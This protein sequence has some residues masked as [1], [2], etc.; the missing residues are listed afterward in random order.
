MKIRLANNLMVILNHELKAL[1]IR[2]IWNLA[3]LCK[4]FDSPPQRPQENLAFDK[5][6]TREWTK[7]L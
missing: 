7:L 6:P 5:G 3:T 4:G 1:R 2:E